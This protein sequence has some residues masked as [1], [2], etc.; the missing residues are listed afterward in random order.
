MQR[1]DRFSVSPQTPLPLVRPA[2]PAPPDVSAQAVRPLAERLAGYQ[3][4]LELVAVNGKVLWITL[5]DSER[6]A[7]AAEPT[8]DEEMP[9]QLGDVTCSRT[10]RAVTS[11]SITTRWSPTR[12]ANERYR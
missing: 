2:R 1:V 3:S 10:G 8:F 5:F 11:P 12:A 6:N 9:R 4:H 7:Q